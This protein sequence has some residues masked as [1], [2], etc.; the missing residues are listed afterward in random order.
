MGSKYQTMGVY[1][2]SAIDGLFSRKI[3]QY[4]KKNKIGFLYNP[5]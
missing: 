2:I 4:M 3:I 5:S 1:T